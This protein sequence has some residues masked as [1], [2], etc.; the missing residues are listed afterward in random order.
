MNS[1]AYNTLN[2]SFRNKLVFRIGHESGFFSEYNNMI[3]AIHYCL[4]NHIQFVLNSR[5]SNFSIKGWTDFFL[6]FCVEDNHDLHTTFNK[7]YE[8]P[9]IRGKKNKINFL[10][11][12]VHLLLKNIDY[13]TFDVFYKARQQSLS[14]RAEIPE[15]N[16]HGTLLENCVKLNQMIWNYQPE[17]LKEIEY[18]ISTLDLKE[19]YISFH[20]RRGDKIYE[21]D[22][23]DCKKYIEKSEKQTDIRVAFIATDDYTVIEEIRTDFPQWK[24]F[25]LTTPEERGYDQYVFNE[26]T[27]EQKRKELIKLFATVEI[28]S[29]SALFVGTMSSNIGMY[30]AWRLPKEKC[31]GVDF[32]DWRIW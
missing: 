28:M 4:A 24:L 15:L 11:Y 12:Q 5:N 23:I 19:A 31:I 16:L 17:A 13:L 9:I 26:M 14:E 8:K 6:P 3:L 10:K 2:H 29:K 25:T 21:S 20:I 22:Y 30:M 1:N 32:N 27:P 7:R 18:L